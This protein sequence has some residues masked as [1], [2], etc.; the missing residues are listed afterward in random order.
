MLQ[1]SIGTRIARMGAMHGYKPSGEIPKPTE[2]QPAAT[3]GHAIK[4]A[5]FWA[6]LAGVVAGAIIAAA[7]IAVT[8]AL[9]GGPAV[10]VLGIAAV[11][12]MGAAYAASELG[13]PGVASA[14]AKVGSAIGDGLMLGMT[15]MI[16]GASNAV[17]NFFEDMGSMD[18]TIVT[19]AFGVVIEGALAA[20]AGVKIKEP[21]AP[22][23]AA[24]SSLAEGV[25]EGFSAGVTDTVACSKHTSA[26]PPKI[27]EGSD[28]V[29]INGQPAARKG[30]KI[31]CGATIKQGAK[32]V[33][34]GVEGATYLNVAEEFSWWQKAIFIAV[35]FLIPP[36]RG[37]VKGF[38]KLFTRAG[39]KALVK[40]AKIGALK[41]ARNVRRNS[42]CARHAFKNNTGFKR[43]SESTKK[44]FKGD[45]IDVV[46]GRVM[47]QRTDFELGQTIPLFFTRTFVADYVGK[48]I[49]AKN[50]ADNF[51]EC[52]LLNDTQDLIEVQLFDGQSLYFSLPAGF[53]EACNPE[54]PDYILARSDEGFWLTD[55]RNRISRQFIVSTTNP[56]L[57]LL[58]AHRDLH[59]NSIVFHRDEQQRLTKVHHSDGIVLTFS[60][61][62][63]GYLH[64]I[65]RIDSGLNDVLVSYQQNTQGYLVEADS[66]TYYHLFYDYTSQGWI[67]R[68]FDNDK[69]WTRYE[70][71]GVG[72]CTFSEAA[73]G[74]YTVTFNYSPGCTE[75]TDGKGHT[76]HYY[77]D[78][79]QRV[80]AVQQPD[81][82]TTRYVYDEFD[83]LLS[84]ISP[85]GRTIA[86][87]YLG[88]TGLVSRYINEAG[89]CWQYTYN[90]AQQLTSVKDPFERVWLQQY[91]DKGEPN[92]FLA[93]D[94]SA[95]TL[96]YNAAGLVV[97]VESSNGMRQFLNYD[98][99]HHLLTLFNE[100]R[101]ALQLRYD[102]QGRVR[103]LSQNGK[104]EWGYQYDRR[105]RLIKN[106]RPNESHEDFTHDRHGNL[107]AY[108][109]ANGVVWRMEYGAFDLPMART[110]GEGNR[111]QYHYD[112][113]TLA[114]CRVTNPAGESYQY[115]LN[116][117]GRVIT[118]R[119]Y[120]GTEW[121]Y[122]YDED[123]NCI[124][125]RDALGQ[126]TRYEYDA[127]CQLLV[128]TT[129]EGETRNIYDRIGRLLSVVT[130]G[131]ELAF[132]YDEND[133]IVREVNQ[134]REIT[135]EYPDEFTVIRHLSSANSAPVLTTVFHYNRVGELTGV[136][137]PDAQHLKFIS[138]KEGHERERVSPAGFMFCQDY[139]EMGMLTRQRAGRQTQIFSPEEVHDI[140]RPT[141]ASL[142]R[143]Y[144]YDA[145]LNLVGANDDNE[146]LSY[147]VNGNQQVVSVS[148]GRSLKEHYRYDASG[149]VAQRQIG[150]QQL[151]AHDEIYQRGHRLKQLGQNWYE[152]DVAGRMT[153]KRIQR[154]GYRPEYTRF[155]WNS[156]D[157]LVALKDAQGRRWQYRY[158][159]FGRRTEKCCEEQGLRVSYL[160]DG[161][162][163]AEIR[164]YR[165]GY[166][167]KVRHWV[168]N[169]WELIAQQECTYATE[170][171]EEGVRW[172]F[173]T[174]FAVCAPS[175]QPLALFN[176]AGKRV[177]R[178]PQESL[179]GIAL[180]KAD[181]NPQLD[182]GLKFAGQLWDAES[183]LHYNRFRYY[184]PQAGCYLTSDPLG[185]EGGHNPY[186]YV[187]NPLSAVDPLGLAS[188]NINPRL[189][190]RLSKWKDYK[191]N[192][193]Q[194]S[195]K[196]W[197]GH[198]RSQPW[199]H[200][201]R[202]GYADWV[203][204]T[205]GRIHGN[206]RLATGA[207]DVYVIREAGTNRLLH[208]GETG[209]GYMTRFAEHQK[210]F[211]ALGI[212]IY[213]SRL[214]TVEGKAA[215]RALELRYITTYERIFGKMPPYNPVYH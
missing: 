2:G 49:V 161:D 172:V 37:M 186:S 97:T 130:E 31:E 114:L 159:P 187:S 140:P 48:G 168:F 63:N 98:G 89:E 149:Y 176:T 111:W 108:S 116:E 85:Q 72:R 160:W 162:S 94:G 173:E 40:G 148:N 78:E 39:R 45:P 137:L 61:H 102:K 213:S 101:G 60:W 174:Q 17:T 26:P 41:T 192:G 104:N 35:E 190:D 76:T 56:T 154:E 59:G 23:S 151:V 13:S 165:H 141:L 182:P 27:A 50:W 207:H 6:K 74:Y 69:T 195:M 188:C 212:D 203:K 96:N 146:R 147:V 109:D 135:R 144:Q 145:A 43:F 38:G 215:A 21:G 70:Y 170:P 53:D 127:C 199:G 33:F 150:E 10:L 184:D 5:S 82:S 169:G 11:G 42:G 197:V 193:G 86:F 7:V 52:L 66:L 46:T 208:F 58:H 179:W 62:V 177:W 196:Q 55:R 91:D 117:V 115:E 167:Q 100:E 64:Q 87:E 95:T 32:T 156:K 123:G 125:K 205:S 133:R 44:F 29:F 198:T 15:D 84:Q 36:S 113:D 24:D 120:A 8:T 129:P 54:H 83:H 202:G 164:E 19:G 134:E 14:A 75:V 71:D 191:A 132:T 118:E 124:E 153:V 181:Q 214:A 107:T 204:A 136:D 92:H 189:Q 77:Y 3:I 12:C 185:L 57:C 22:A 25:S 4:H 106:T 90:S 103:S 143:T 80:T 122:S 201:P 194:M 20:R 139:D 131:D 51:S 178:R 67:S 183:G 142:D 28:T 155:I 152:Y 30:D 158:D 157:Q 180:G 79:Q 16:T 88:T 47:E 110:D 119:D 166:L 163:I 210:R 81:G 206:S 121:H 112:K 93:P 34:I 99:Q 73:E 68:W 9:I 128:V 1:Q 211:E 175:G 65:I 126:V 209:R 171:S 18:G 200:G 138:D 105:G